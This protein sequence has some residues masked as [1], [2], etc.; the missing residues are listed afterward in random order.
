MAPKCD[1][2]GKTYGKKST[3]IQHKRIVHNQF[4][5]FSKWA[6]HPPTKDYECEACGKLFY[7][8]SNLTKHIK[9][10]H[11]GAKQQKEHICDSCG[12]AYYEARD[13]KKH[14]GRCATEAMTDV[15]CEKCG[16]TYK[17]MQ[18]MRNHLRF[19]HLVGAKNVLVCDYCN[20]KFS[21]KSHLRMHK[22]NIHLE[23]PNKHTCDQCGKAVY[24]LR[25][26]IE[27]VHQGLKPFK[28]EFCG[29][30]F[31][32]VASMQRHIRKFLLL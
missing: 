30:V 2:C 22:D 23:N 1:I 14:M 31:A 6:E 26:H 24:H 29:N 15:K 12:K 19:M 8:E 5:K 17:N 16:K 21:T 4:S 3:V 13:L 20:K 11:E 9:R 7:L 10:F 27:S 18:L 25:K 32:T 28:C